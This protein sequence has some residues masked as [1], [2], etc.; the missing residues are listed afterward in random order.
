[1]ISVKLWILVTGGICLFY[2]G[3]FIGI[4]VVSLFS[5]NKEDYEEPYTFD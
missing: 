5:G 4:I 3:M 1:M 2:L